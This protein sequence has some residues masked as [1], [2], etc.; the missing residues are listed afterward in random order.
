[1]ID[2]AFILVC[3]KDLNGLNCF[4]SGVNEPSVTNMPASSVRQQPLVTSNNNLKGLPRLLSTHYMLSNYSPLKLITLLQAKLHCHNH[5]LVLI[6][7]SNLDS[8]TKI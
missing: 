6:F 4:Y 5:F 8:K 2:I 1:M 3:C 7:E